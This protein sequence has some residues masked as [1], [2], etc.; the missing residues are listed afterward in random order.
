M[1]NKKVKKDKKIDESTYAFNTN[2]QR[3]RNI[4]MN[5]RW[6]IRRMK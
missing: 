5:K 6:M 4:F 1:V 3:F 2:E